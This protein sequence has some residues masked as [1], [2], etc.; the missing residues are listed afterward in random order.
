MGESGEA[1]FIFIGK[2]S[3]WK[4]REGL[5]GNN[6][7]VWGRTGQLV[8]PPSPVFGDGLLKKLFKIRRIRMEVIFVKLCTSSCVEAKYLLV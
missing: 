8:S 5:V 7:D 3:E 1:R 6:S 2:I 4:L